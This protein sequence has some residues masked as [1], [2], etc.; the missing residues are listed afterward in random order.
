MGIQK[1]TKKKVGKIYLILASCAAD[2]RDITPLDIVHL[3]CSL[4]NHAVIYK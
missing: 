4:C 3:I 2:D 1:T